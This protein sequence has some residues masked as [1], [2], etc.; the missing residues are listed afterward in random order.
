[1][2]TISVEQELLRQ[3]LKKHGIEHDIEQMDDRLPL[4]G[5]DIDA[6]NEQLLE[7]EI[8][9]D[10]PDLLSGE[11]LARAIRPFLHGTQSEPALDVVKGALT[12][13]VEPE[14]EHIRPVIMGAVVRGLDIGGD[15]E[16]KDA[17]IKGLMEHQEK[18]H[19]ALGRGR[20]RAS[21]GVHDLSTLSPP[22]SVK[23]VSGDACFVPLGMEHEMSLHEIL[24][25]H[26]KGIDFAHLLEGMDTF[27]IITDRQGK[28][29]SFPPIIN[30]NHTTVTHSTQDFFI[31][32]TGWDRRACES[33]LML[34]ALQLAERGGTIESVEVTGCDG[35]TEHLPKAE[36]I[37]H[38][39]TQRLLDGL[40]GRA[41]TDEEIAIGI[42]RMGGR[43]L[44]RKNATICTA[45]PANR[46]ADVV[47]GDVVLT[48]AMPRW[49]FDIL[50]PIDLVED[51][52]I[53]HG[54]EDLGNDVPRAPL[55]AIPRDDSHMRRR[56]RESLQGLGLMQI[57]SL[58]LSNDVDQFEA[59]R[60][61]E[62]GEVTRITNPITIEHTLLRQ[63][64][65]PG[66]F[67]LMASNRHH[68]LPQAVYELGTVVRNHANGDR[69]AFLVAEQGGGF[70]AVR[71]RIQAL[72]RDL[73]EA[74][75]TIEPLS[76]T[77]GPWLAGRSAKVIIKGEHVGCFGEMDPSVS[78]HYELR[79][80]LSG[81]EFDIQALQSVLEDPV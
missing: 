9:P 39:V 6:C 56:I 70:A 67:R 55:T 10:R 80:P 16:D 53:G 17:F 5:T 52:A 75:Y 4:L 2:P 44:G 11:T 26:S 3:L 14:L 76:G 79:V 18:L 33:S 64:L 51:V 72:M 35:T 73:G 21:I 62:M 54:Y 48:F 57:Q 74:D 19:F 37:E 50:H 47:E 31:E 66:L 46:M 15:S 58:T 71:G 29:L 41:L 59:M 7:I 68:D 13:S 45:N 8:F 63:Y 34:V 28:I 27:P 65:L 36:P 69:F 30:G 81:A 77:M 43:F 42:N 22:F 1:M 32:V 12:M 24:S 78:A 60:W 20:R 61:P 40:L 38:Q 49:R 25:S 23:A